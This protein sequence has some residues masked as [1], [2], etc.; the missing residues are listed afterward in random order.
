[1]KE[2]VRLTANVHTN[3]VKLKAAGHMTKDPDQAFC[4]VNIGCG[5]VP[6]DLAIFFSSAEEMKQLGLAIAAEAER[7]LAAETEE[8]K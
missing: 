5:D 6:L 3:G 1:M 8:N 4:W 2:T 7:L